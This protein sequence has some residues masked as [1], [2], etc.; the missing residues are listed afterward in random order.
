MTN[1]KNSEGRILA[2]DLGQ[3]RVGLAVS[4]P[5]RNF[6]STKGMIK[7]KSMDDL[8]G[9]IGEHIKTEEVTEIVLGLPLHLSGDESEGSKK[10]REF[11]KALEQKFGLRVILVDESLSTVQAEDILI[12]ANISRKKRKKVIDGLAAAV[13][14][15]SYLN[16]LCEEEN[17]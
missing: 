2:I 7:R 1:H 14:L 16:E 11:G 13:F 10:A 12:E 9:K 5:G 15:Q 8:L 4:D 3:K 17:T 6:A